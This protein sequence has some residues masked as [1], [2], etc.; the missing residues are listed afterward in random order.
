MAA[1]GY[2]AFHH[3]GGVVQKWVRRGQKGELTI[4]TN[5]TSAAFVLA[6]HAA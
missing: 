1:E 6:L 3:G 4:R 2:L 5:L